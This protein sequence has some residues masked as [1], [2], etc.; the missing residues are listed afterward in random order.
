MNSAA[1]SLSTHSAEE[2]ALLLGALLAAP[3]L[4]EAL[5]NLHPLDFSLPAHRLIWKALVGLA[6]QE[7][8]RSVQAVGRWLAARGELEL[9]GGVEY[10]ERLVRGKSGRG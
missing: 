2:E 7:A 6:Y 9:A 4:F 1:C 8:P 3:F 5:P 10:L